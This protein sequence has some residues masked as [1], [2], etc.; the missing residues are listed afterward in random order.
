MKG[1]TK[2]KY[3]GGKLFC[4]LIAESRFTTIISMS[5]HYEIF[6]TRFKCNLLVLDKK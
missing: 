1:S 2:M 5:Y 3:K 4:V 6:Y